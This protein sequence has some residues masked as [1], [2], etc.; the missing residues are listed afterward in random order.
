MTWSKYKLMN[1]R[2]SASMENRRQLRYRV[3]E[4]GNCSICNNLSPCM[5]EKSSFCTGICGLRMHVQDEN[6]SCKRMYNWL[7]EWQPSRVMF[8]SCSESLFHVYCFTDLTWWVY[9]NYLSQNVTHF[10]DNKIISTNLF[11]FKF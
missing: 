10:F 3:G 8:K 7:D 2:K 11:N 5:I 4:G 1:Y 6:S 9:I